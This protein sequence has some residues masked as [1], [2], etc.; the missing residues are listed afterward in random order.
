RVF[1]NEAEKRAA[2]VHDVTSQIIEYSKDDLATFSSTNDMEALK[3]VAVGAYTNEE[4]G[5]YNSMIRKN[6]QEAGI[7]KGKG[8][9]YRSGGGKMVELALGDQI[10]FKSNKG[11]FAGYGGVDNN[12][13]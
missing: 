3:L 12:E 5:L 7:V 8:R 1:D 10:I 6:L 2:L 4:V 13:I 9:L 11:E